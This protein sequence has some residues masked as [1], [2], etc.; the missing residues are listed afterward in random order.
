MIKRDNHGKYLKHMFVLVIKN[1]NNKKK[2]KEMNS[3]QNLRK[4]YLSFDK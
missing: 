3:Y 2:Q 1:K 4:L